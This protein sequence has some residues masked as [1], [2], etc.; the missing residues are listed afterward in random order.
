VGRSVPGVEVANE[1]QCVGSGSPFSIPHAGF[2]IVCTVVESKVEMTIGHGFK[3]RELTLYST[4]SGC[5]PLNA[6]DQ[7]IMI[8]KK[9]VV[10]F[11]DL[12]W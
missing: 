9:S 5:E 2:T 6:G 4:T 8:R 3:R 11:D 1:V 10:V 7:V 12:Q